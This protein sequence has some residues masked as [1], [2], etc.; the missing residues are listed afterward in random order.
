MTLPFVFPFCSHC[1]PLRSSENIQRKNKSSSNAKKVLPFK[2]VAATSHVTKIMM[3]S[4]SQMSVHGT[5]TVMSLFWSKVRVYR[6]LMSSRRI[7]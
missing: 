7:G 3:S 2:I 5:S 4:T 1:V 6:I